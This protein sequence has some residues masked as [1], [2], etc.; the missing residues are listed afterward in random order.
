[1]KVSRGAE[2]WL[3]ESQAR[4][5]ISRFVFAIRIPS[6]D[7]PRYSSILELSKRPEI[8]ITQELSADQEKKKF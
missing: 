3:A 5:V 1:M 8:Q 6:R 2:R 7:K 4:A